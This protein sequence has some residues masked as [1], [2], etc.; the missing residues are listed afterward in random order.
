M[1]SVHSRSRACDGVFNPP[2]N[3]KVYK[4]NKH[5]APADDIGAFVQRAYYI[6]RY[7]R[8]HYFGRQVCAI[9]MHEFSVSVRYMNNIRATEQERER[10][11]GTHFTCSLVSNIIS[12]T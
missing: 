1:L 3:V 7:T 9:Y 10:E 6:H 11:I 4:Y 12:I 8:V 5:I 2:K